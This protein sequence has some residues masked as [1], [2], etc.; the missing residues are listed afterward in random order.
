MKELEETWRLKKM[1]VEERLEA[2]ILAKSL[3]ENGS[4]VLA[5]RGGTMGRCR[6]VN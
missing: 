5:A 1:Y 4:A 6:S 3:T 2:E